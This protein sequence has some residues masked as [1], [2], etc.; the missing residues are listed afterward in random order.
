MTRGVV[1]RVRPSFLPDQS[2]HDR[3]RFVWAYAVEIE[4]RRGETVQLIGRHWVITDALNHVEIVDGPGVVGEQPALQPG[5]TFSY[6]SACPLT[7]PSGAMSGVYRMITASGAQFD[8]EIPAFSLHLPNAA[9]R[10]N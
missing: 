6:T 4:N 1:V 3:A 2:D 5:D 7:T 10:L 8:A 9:Q